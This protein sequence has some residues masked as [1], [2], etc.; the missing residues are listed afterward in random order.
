VLQEIG[1]LRELIFRAAGEGT[2]RVSD[3]DLFDAYYL[4]L[5]I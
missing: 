3:I 5:F 4:H 2:G 1:R